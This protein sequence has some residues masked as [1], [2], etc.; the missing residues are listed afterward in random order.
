[1]RCSRFAVGRTLI[2]AAH[3]AFAGLGSNAGLRVPATTALP[4]TSVLPAAGRFFHVVFA[5][6]S[7][8]A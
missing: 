3:A 1:M 2:G 4:G 6:G 5:R 8:F 7:F